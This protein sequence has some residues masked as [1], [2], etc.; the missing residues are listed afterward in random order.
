MKIKK[1]VRFLKKNIKNTE[2][3]TNKPRTTEAVL[4]D[5]M[6]NKKKV[7]YYPGLE[8]LL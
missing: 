7:G 8:L 5:F 2:K 3:P 6:C 1:L 4:L